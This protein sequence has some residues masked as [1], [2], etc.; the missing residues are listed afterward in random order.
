[1][2][3]VDK[4]LMNSLFGPMKNWSKIKVINVIVIDVTL[5]LEA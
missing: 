1:M 3:L 5:W 2:T 4:E